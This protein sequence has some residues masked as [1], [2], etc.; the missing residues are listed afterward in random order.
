LY[1]IS[2]HAQNEHLA[3]S[4]PSSIPNFEFLHQTL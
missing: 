1:Y 2:F 4:T 3:L